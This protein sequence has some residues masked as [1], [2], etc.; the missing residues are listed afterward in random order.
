[1]NYCPI[2]LND[3]LS[4][5]SRGLVEIVINGKKMDAGRF[6][7]N[8]G[9]DTQDEILENFRDKM[10]EFFRWYGNFQNKDP[11]SSVEIVSS[12]FNCEH[13]C[14]ID[15]TFK[16]S[17]IDLLIPRKYLHEVLQELCNDFD[18]KLDI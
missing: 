14:R 13:G 11:I 15:L 10:E 3:S 16:G 6:I 17:V 12:D 18:L 2:C 1:M 9:K 7:F 5:N 8:V 4:L